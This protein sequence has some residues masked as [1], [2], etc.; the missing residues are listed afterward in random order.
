MATEVRSTGKATRGKQRR[1]VNL[2][3]LPGLT[4]NPGAEESERAT[5][6]IAC[7]G[8]IQDTRVVVSGRSTVRTER[9]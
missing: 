8:T 4:G 3:A 5:S 9:R 7:A 6:A 1:G 2:G